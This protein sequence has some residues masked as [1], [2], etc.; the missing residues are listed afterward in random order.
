MEQ[1]QCECK[2][3]IKNYICQ[4]YHI[5]N[6]CICSCECSNKYEIDECLNS[7][8]CKKSVFDNLFITCKYMI[9]NIST[10]SFDKKVTNEMD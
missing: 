10:T 6:P 3:S 7:C 5:Q 9:V 1:F 8:T 4:K 2:K